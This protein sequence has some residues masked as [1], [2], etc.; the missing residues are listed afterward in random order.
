MIVGSRIK[1]SKCCASTAASV[2]TSSP[3]PGPLSGTRGSSATRR[4][5]SGRSRPGTEV[6]P[7]INLQQNNYLF[8]NNKK[9]KLF[10]TKFIFRVDHRDGSS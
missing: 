6:G 1:L 4:R 3:P 2:T 5:R 9:G 8:N 7:Q 10:H